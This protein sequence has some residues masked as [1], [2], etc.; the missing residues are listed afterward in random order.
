[1]T[2]ILEIESWENETF[3]ACELGDPRR[4]RRLVQVTQRI[5][6]HPAGSFPAQ[7]PEWAELKAAYRL[8]AADDVTFRAVAVPHWEQTR[9]AASGKTLV[10]CKV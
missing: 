2:G 1:M 5:S 10:I 8:F 7:M 4:T 6:G 3:G 9:N